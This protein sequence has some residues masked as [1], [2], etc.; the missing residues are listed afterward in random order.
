MRNQQARARA[1]SRR[2]TGLVTDLWRNQYQCENSRLLSFYPKSQVQPIG[3][4][5]LQGLF[6]GAGKSQVTGFNKKE[7]DP[8]MAAH[9]EEATPCFC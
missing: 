1:P 9:R 4:G 8:I 7:I 5:G 6:H 2:L 3:K